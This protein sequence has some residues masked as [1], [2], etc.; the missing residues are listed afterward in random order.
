MNPASAP[1]RWWSIVHVV[2]VLALGI[3]T[4]ALVMTAIAAGLIFK[5]ARE[6]KP[7]L[8]E[9]AGYH[10]DH[11]LLTGGKIAS[12][13]FLAVDII[14]FACGGLA[15]LTLGLLLIFGRERMGRLHAA[16]RVITLTLPL[17]VLMFYLFVLSPRMTQNL[18]DHWDAAAQGDQ[19]RAD[20][21]KA[22]FDADHPTSSTAL[23]AT[24]VLLL[25]AIGAAA[26][27][28]RREGPEL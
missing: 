24:V 1:P 26:W 18:R 9:F 3:W 15:I 13:L 7:T 28:A 6:I 21:S 20:A 19:A 4:G 5:T 23:S 2:H 11:A 27:P 14:Q 12:R 17:C 8:P 25:G 22:A 10:G 16:L